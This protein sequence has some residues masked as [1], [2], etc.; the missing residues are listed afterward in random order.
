MKLGTSFSGLATA[1]NKVI[2]LYH[3]QEERLAKA[4]DATFGYVSCAAAVGSEIVFTY[5]H[6]GIINGSTRS[7]VDQRIVSFARRV[8]APWIFGFDPAELEGYLMARGLKLIE[9]VGVSEY[10]ARYLAPLD[11]E[12]NIFESERV[13]LARVSRKDPA[14]QPDRLRRLG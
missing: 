11:R 4:V 14:L 12:M 1:A 7:E 6:R 13:V 5:I 9:E 10:R 2:E 3:P 8:G